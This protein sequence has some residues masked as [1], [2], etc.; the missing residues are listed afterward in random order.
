MYPKLSNFAKTLIVIGAVGFVA[1]MIITCNACLQGCGNNHSGQGYYSS[2]PTYIPTQPQ[3]ITVTQPDG[4]SFLMN[5]L[6]WKSLMDNGGQTNVYNYYRD[7]RNDYDFQPSRQN[8]YREQER[9]YQEQVKTQK[10]NGFGSKPVETSKSNGF[11]GRSV[12]T[13][14]S[15][16]FGTYTPSTTTSS[17]STSTSTKKSSGFGWGSSSSASNNSVST[18]KSS[19]FG[20]SSSKSTSTSKSSGFGSRKKN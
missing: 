2:Q 4:S 12:D 6:L 3:V 18:K 5:Y 8:E 1:M 17:G 13:K 7:H 15:S 11:G 9:Q 19:G 14:K 20:S 16:G 10:S